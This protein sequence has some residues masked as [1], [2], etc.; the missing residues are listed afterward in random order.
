LPHLGVLSTLRTKGR[1]FSVLPPPPLP[2]PTLFS[3]FDSRVF[4]PCF[5]FAPQIFQRPLELCD[6]FSLS[7]SRPPPALVLFCCWLTAFRG[8]L[9]GPGGRIQF[10]FRLKFRETHAQ[11]R[12]HDPSLYFF[13]T[14]LGPL[15]QDLLTDVPVMVLLRSIFFFLCVSFRPPLRMLHIFFSIGTPLSRMRF[16]FFPGVSGICLLARNRTRFRGSGCLLL[17]ISTVPLV[18]H[19]QAVPF[20]GFPSLIFFPKL[21]H[22]FPPQT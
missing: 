15:F 7:A 13:L 3:V 1:F 12:F 22:T 8:L 9:I 14:D 21:T 18:C 17:E 2:C 6:F 4:F 5:P 11:W 16:F 10:P 19:V 20:S